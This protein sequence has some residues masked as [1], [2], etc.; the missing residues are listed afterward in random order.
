MNTQMEQQSVMHKPVKKGARRH[1]TVCMALITMLMAANAQAE[2]LGL[3]NGRL[4]TFDPDQTLSVELGYVTGKIAGADYDNPGLRIN[5]LLKDDIQLF[6]DL[7]KTTVGRGDENAYGFGAFYKLGKLFKFTDFVTLKGSFHTIKLTRYISG[8]YSSNCT[9]PSP[10]INPFDGSLTIDPGYCYPTLLDGS[11][12]SNTVQIFAMEL[13][14]GGK[15][16]EQLR[17]K[18]KLPSWYA[19]L[20]V[21]S[22]QG[23]SLGSELSVGGGLVLPLG[24]GELYAGLDLIDELLMGI[25]YRYNLK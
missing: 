13:L 2:Y 19:N 3:P 15:P 14:F 23:S 8:G 7:S 22:F 25:G 10:V 4:G 9:G 20:G 1:I 12:S 6:A 24:S 18:D 16:V 11:N 17:F 21:N 5:Y